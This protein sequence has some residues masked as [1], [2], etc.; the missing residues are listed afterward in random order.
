MEAQGT[1][2][3]LTIWYAKREVVSV[4][5]SAPVL[6]LVTRLT[7]QHVHNVHSVNAL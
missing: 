6:L 3:S 5:V 1:E 4:I 2:E 7:F